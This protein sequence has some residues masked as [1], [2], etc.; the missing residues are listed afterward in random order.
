MAVQFRGPETSF[1][2]I[3]G[4]A[5]AA[6]PAADKDE[7]K[8]SV[9]ALFTALMRDE[10]GFAAFEE[11]LHAMHNITLTGAAVRLLHSTD[12]TSGRLKYQQFQKALAEGGYEESDVAGKPNLL[13]DQAGAIIADNSGAAVPGPRYAAPKVH[14]DISVDDFAKQHSKVARNQQAKGAFA[15]NPVVQ[16]NQVS[17]GNPLAQ[18]RAANAPVDDDRE[19]GQVATRM[20]ASGELNRREYEEFLAGIGVALS[21]ESELL[22][23][24]IS[25]EKV[26]DGNFLKLSKAL[27]SELAAESRAQAV[28][29]NSVAAAAARRAPTAGVAAYG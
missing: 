28:A 26:G 8:P 13:K 21:R 6:A 15:S 2:K 10:L 9:N 24:I 16:S 4:G 5:A 20:Y 23:L 29:A 12:A 3:F 27:Q 25:H 22:R 11:L 18:S 7:E 19:V 1:D 14:T 17:S